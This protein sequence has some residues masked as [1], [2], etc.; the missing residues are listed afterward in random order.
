MR[1]FFICY[2]YTILLGDL[3]KTKYASTTLNLTIA[4]FSTYIIHVVTSDMLFITAE[5]S[6]QVNDVET[7]N[8][9]VVMAE[10]SYKVDYEKYACVAMG[11]Y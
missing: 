2:Q 10:F 8:M 5:F 11:I 7:S 1:E 3:R 9:L 6:F 4:L